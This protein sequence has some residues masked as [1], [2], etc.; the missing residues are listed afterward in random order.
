VSVLPAL[1]EPK[2]FR[3]LLE[4]LQ[5]NFG[6]LKARGSIL[7]FVRQELLLSE[8]GCMVEAAEAAARMK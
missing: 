6:L 2:E 5:R 1:L 3:D 8:S 7:G 4:I